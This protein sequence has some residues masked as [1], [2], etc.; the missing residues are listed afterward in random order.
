MVYNMYMNVG[1][2]PVPWYLH[3]LHPSRRP[4]SIYYNKLDNFYTKWTSVEDRIEFYTIMNTIKRSRT[5]MKCIMKYFELCCYY[6][7]EWNWYCSRID[8]CMQRLVYINTQEILETRG[9]STASLHSAISTASRYIDRGAGP[10]TEQ[11]IVCITFA[12]A[13]GIY[14]C[15]PEGRY[16]CH[17]Q[18]NTHTH[19]LVLTP[20]EHHLDTAAW[21]YWLGL[22][23][24]LTET[25][26]GRRSDRGSHHTLNWKIYSS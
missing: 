7:K 12:D 22:C 10:V 21:S 6:V 2:H 9:R 19:A 23:N 11:I 25:Q 14:Q 20:F 5:I 1:A 4:R 16:N 26:F 24:G 18:T 15:T 3:P 13:G 17:S 8:E